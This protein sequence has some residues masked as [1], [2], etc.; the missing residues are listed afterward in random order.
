M[1]LRIESNTG[2]LESRCREA[3]R[4]YQRE[5]VARLRSELPWR[6][7]AADALR[8]I[9]QPNEGRLVETIL[10]GIGMEAKPA[11]GVTWVIAVPDVGISSGGN[12][13]P[14]RGGRP[15]S[16]E[17]V[18]DR[19]RRIQAAELTSAI[20][21][22]DAEEAVRAWVKAPFTSRSDPAS[23]KDL[24]VA[25]LAR[26]PEPIE[27]TIE[28]LLRIMGLVPITMTETASADRAAAAVR[29]QRRVE[30]FIEA[31]QGTHGTLV[32]K[33]RVRTL[34]DAIILAWT[35][36]VRAELPPLARRVMVSLLQ[37]GT[38]PLTPT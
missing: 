23:G 12:E 15:R 24:T 9:A 29:L 32:S 5:L 8:G 25:D 19:R 17:D 30:G 27:A 16:D 21:V 26:G 2:P 13:R 37:P 4:R 7:T 20:G 36:M 34:L 6:S 22:I 38:L 14:D 3:L 28:A 11:D 10:G 35:E 1:K 31:T 18:E 33:A